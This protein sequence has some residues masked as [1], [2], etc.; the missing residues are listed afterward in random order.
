MVE[1]VEP[2]PERGGR[3]D[4]AASAVLSDAVDEDVRHHLLV[5]QRGITVQAAL[6]ERERG[7]PLAAGVMALRPDAGEDPGH[8]RQFIGASR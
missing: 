2:V 3:T 5:T 6:D 8:G 4:P 7:L 1:R